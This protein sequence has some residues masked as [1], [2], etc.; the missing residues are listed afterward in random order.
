MCVLLF[1]QHLLY[2]QYGV[3]VQLGVLFEVPAG[4]DIKVLHILVPD[5]Y[6]KTLSVRPAP[7]QVS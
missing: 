5:H 1:K 2:L 7:E 6:I 3:N 4:L